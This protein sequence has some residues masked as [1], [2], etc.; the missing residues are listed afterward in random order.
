[1]QLHRSRK[2]A[3]FFDHRFGSEINCGLSVQE[4]RVRLFFRKIWGHR[5]TWSSN[6]GMSQNVRHNLAL[7]PL[8]IGSYRRQKGLSTE[9]LRNWCCIPLD[10]FA[11][12]E[13]LS[14]FFFSSSD[15]NVSNWY[16]WRRSM[17]FAATNVKE[18]ITKRQGPSFLNNHEKKEPANRRTFWHLSEVTNVPRRFLSDSY[19]FLPLE[20]LYYQ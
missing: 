16:L 20:Q 11:K 19:L 8:V 6:A 1:M 14:T 13:H 4:A 18:K 2:F 9:K 10:R 7:T 15:T 5:M 17:R 3:S 12:R